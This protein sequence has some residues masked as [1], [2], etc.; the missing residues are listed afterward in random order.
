MKK[1]ALAA[2]LAGAAASPAFAA[3]GLITVASHKGVSATMSCLESSAKEKGLKVVARVDHAAAAAGAG[4]TLRPTQLLIFGNPKIGTALMAS[5]QTSG[6]DLPL[7]ALA[8]ED[9]AGK[10]WL[11]YNDPEYLARRHG[12]TDRAEVL[13]KMAGALKGLSERA[14]KAGGC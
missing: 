3:D 11:A 14:T 9:A 8:W 6:I 12:I 4:Q 5:Q 10:V 2:I 7:K 13:G 1:I